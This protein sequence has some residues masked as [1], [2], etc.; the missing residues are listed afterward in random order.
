MGCRV[1][2]E[3]VH[4]EQS[5]ADMIELRGEADV[6]GDPLGVQQFQVSAGVITGGCKLDIHGG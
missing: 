3:V 2:L 1:V 4:G 6:A 5:F